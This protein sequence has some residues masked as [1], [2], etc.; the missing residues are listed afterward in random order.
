K[1]VGFKGEVVVAAEVADADQD[2]CCGVRG[3][4]A[5]DGTDVDGPT[6]PTSRHLSL[7]DQVRPGTQAIEFVV[8]GAVRFDGGGD[9]LAEM[10]GA[11]KRDFQA[12]AAKVVRVKHMVLVLV[13]VQEA[14]EA[15]RLEPTEVVAQTRRSRAD[16]QTREL[17]RLDGAANGARRIHAALE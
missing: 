3:G 1:V 13:G 8:A 17:V 5:A 14:T 4:E 7:L 12:L 10:M 16:D 9:G 15:G 2:V 11:R 6:L